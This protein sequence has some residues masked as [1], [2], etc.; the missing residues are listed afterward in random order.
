M[1]RD[2]GVVEIRVYDNPT[3]GSAV[4]RADGLAERSRV[5]SQLRRPWA[6]PRTHWTSQN[7]VHRQTNG[8]LL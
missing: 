5:C 3:D 8:L 7:T 4:Q 1:A 2:V 6:A